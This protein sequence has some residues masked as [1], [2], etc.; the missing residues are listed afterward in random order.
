MCFDRR[1]GKRAPDRHRHLLLFSDIEGSTRLLQQLG[2]SWGDVLAE[3]HWLLRGAF[4]EGGGREVD[5][6]G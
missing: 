6:Q 2:D 5:T 1:R 3:H 4:T